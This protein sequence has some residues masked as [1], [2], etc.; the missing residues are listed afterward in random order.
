MPVKCAQATQT[1]VVR[2][3]TS[4]RPAPAAS[5]ACCR[6]RSNFVGFASVPGGYRRTGAKSAAPATASTIGG[7]TSAKS[8]ASATASMVGRRTGANGEFRYCQ[9]GRQKHQ[10]EECGTGIASTTATLDTAVD[11]EIS[12]AFFGAGAGGASGPIVGGPASAGRPGTKRLAVGSE[13]L[14]CAKRGSPPKTW[15]CSVCALI[16][17]ML[18]APVCLVCSLTRSSWAQRSFC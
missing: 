13:Q 7:R 6:F 1:K 16:N 14:P 5:F 2:F 8:A 11:R 18:L 3:R 4:K 9:H 17:H 10:C 12:I 15:V